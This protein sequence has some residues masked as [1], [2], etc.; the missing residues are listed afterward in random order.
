MRPATCVSMIVFGVT[1]FV[2][3][4]AVVLASKTTVDA[5]LF[6]GK[7]PKAAATALL[8][9][10]ERVAGHGSWERIA[11]GSVYYLSGEKDKGQS[12]FD[13]VLG[14][15]PEPSDYL[16]IGWTYARAGEW[17]KAKPMMDKVLELKPKDSDG[18]AQ[19]AAWYIYEGDREGGEELLS[20]ALAL[21]ANDTW[22]YTDAAGAYLGVEPQ[23]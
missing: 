5:T 22:F 17:D 21:A 7:E 23:P 11:I 13:A 2:S 3:G 12:Y 10:A 20:R 9:Q 1:C 8:A 6:Q 4:A 19:V 14:V 16:R 15:A 18:M